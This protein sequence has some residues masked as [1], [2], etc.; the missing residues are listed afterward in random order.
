M[1]ASAIFFSSLAVRARDPPG[2]VQRPGPA[3]PDVKVLLPGVA[4]RTVH[5]QRGAG[6]A[7]RRLSGCQLGHGDVDG[8]SGCVAGH[9]PGRA[10][11]QGT[12]VLD[13]EHDVRQ[14]VLE[15]LERPDRHAELL[16]LP[17]ILHR[18]LDESIS[19]ADQ[20]SRAGERASI[21]RQIEERAR[22]LRLGHQAVR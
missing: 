16:A 3:H 15:G 20:L 10:V 18:Q 14:A 6:G 11:D 7:L 1:Y 9:R 19:G 12:R 17:R 4:D 2:L 5:L 22:G 8:P 13:R 21:E